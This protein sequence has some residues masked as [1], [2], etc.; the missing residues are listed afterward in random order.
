MKM[1]RVFEVL[2]VSSA[3]VVLGILI[4]VPRPDPVADL[5]DE[6]KAQVIALRQSLPE[7]T[8]KD[9]IETHEE[10]F[11]VIGLDNTKQRL[12]IVSKQGKEVFIW[13]CGSGLNRD[14]IENWRQ[15]KRVIKKSDPNWK[16]VAIKFYVED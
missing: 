2:G 3:L 10:T 6:E 5:S 9:F 4:F 1:D 14:N 7:L 13:I 15:I 11:V 16:E 8:K 12:R